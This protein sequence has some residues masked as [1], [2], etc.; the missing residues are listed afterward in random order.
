MSRLRKFP[1]LELSYFDS[2]DWSD[3]YSALVA[4]GTQFI[5]KIASPEISTATLFF[6]LDIYTP[7][8]QSPERVKNATSL[9]LS[10]HG[11]IVA[12]DQDGLDYWTK[13]L[14]D[15]IGARTK[16]TYLSAKE[17]SASGKKTLDVMWSY[18][19]TR[20]EE[21]AGD[22]E[23]SFVRAV[24]I[25]SLPEFLKQFKTEAIKEIK[26]TKIRYLVERSPEAIVMMIPISDLTKAFK[27]FESGFKLLSTTS[28]ETDE[29]FESED[30]DEGVENLKG[31]S[32]EELAAI[33][34]EEESGKTPR[35]KR[36]GEAVEMSHAKY[37][38]RLMKETFWSSFSG[39]M[40]WFT[41]INYRPE[42]DR[43]IDDVLH[44][45][46]PPSD[47]DIDYADMVIT[48]YSKK[49]FNLFIAKA[50]DLDIEGYKAATYDEDFDELE[51]ENQSLKESY[52]ISGY[53]IRG[54]GIKTLNEDPMS[55]GASVFEDDSESADTIADHD[56]TVWSKKDVGALLSYSGD[57]KSAVENIARVI[58][59]GIEDG[60]NE[61]QIVTLDWFKK[62]SRE[63]DEDTKAYIKQ[64]IEELEQYAEWLEEN[65]DIKDAGSEDEIQNLIDKLNAIKARKLLVEDPLLT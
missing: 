16:A 51:T 56:L 3:T 41:N 45:F 1:K 5:F 19:R 7:M 39:G 59:D 27:R 24:S 30:E 18:E 32:D 20:E 54:E 22:T 57:N 13:L 35:G 50:E 23:K 48:F 47:Y 37:R 8:E 36:P 46:I 42:F 38:G 10:G 11:L 52:P 21:E 26:N 53:D 34:Q 61:P 63:S 6:Y 2:L 14:R 43:A 15:T 49:A 33:D 28:E 17:S 65:P 55:F 29:D 44:R 62:S 60:D 9:R 58:F 31:P 12:Q 40:V 25:K 4:L 64:A